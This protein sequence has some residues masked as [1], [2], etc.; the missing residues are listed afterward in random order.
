MVEHNTAPIARL[1]SRSGPPALTPRR[2]IAAAAA[3]AA[4]GFVAAPPAHADTPQIVWQEQHYNRTPL[5]D[6]LVLPMPC[7][8]AMAFRPVATPH[9]ANAL[10]D[11]KIVV[12]EADGDHDYLRGLRE[13]HVSG[14]FRDEATGS[15]RY[16]VAK[17][18]VA[19][20]QYDAVMKPCP[21]P[22]PELKRSSFLAQ[23]GVSWFEAIEFT[24]RYT[25]WLWTEARTSLPRSEGALAFVRLP[26]E[27]EWEFAARG[28]ARVDDVA[29]RRS[30]PDLDGR[31]LAQIAATGDTSSAGGQLQTIGYLAPN[32]LG[33]HDML[34]NVGEMTEDAFRLNRY[35]RLHG[36]TGAF[37]VKGGDARTPSER[38]SLG[39]R[40]EYGFFD[41]ATGL[42]TRDRYVGFRPALGAVVLSS[43][44][45]LAAIQTGYETLRASD[46]DNPALRKADEA[47]SRIDD[48]VTR[49]AE[50][51]GDAAMV[52]DLREARRLLQEAQAERDA[53]RDRALGNQLL[54]GSVACNRIQGQLGAAEAALKMSLHAAEIIRDIE[55]GGDATQVAEGRRRQAEIDD[56]LRQ[57]ES[58]LD[59]SVAFYA[60]LIETLATDYGEAL[61]TSQAAA[62]RRQQIE[63]GQTD[64]LACLD[65]AQRHAAE[66]RT[67]GVLDRE[68]W[69]RDFRN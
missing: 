1:A 21:D 39:M 33:L 60:A 11:L 5:E 31:T 65:H 6:D 15:R 44:E 26:T 36:M 12:G 62:V 37:V 22:L 49:A 14:A 35:G 45:R 28:G 67:N 66:R 59:R 57:V 18:E 61:V 29:F 52:E 24:R 68:A 56:S 23:S 30:L 20:P 50:R 8:G 34:G 54:A 48:A 16:Y 41:P 53:Q 2:G 47:M 4:A 10:A 7:G 27:A 55:A 40:D 38:I 32:P 42:A 25:E 43:Q 9:A 64:I 13:A 3:F 58:A 19:A 69:L 17:F 51:P 63:R 46:P